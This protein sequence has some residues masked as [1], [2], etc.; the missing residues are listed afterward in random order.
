MLNTNSGIDPSSARAFGTTFPAG[1]N[2][3][4]ANAFGLGGGIPGLQNYNMQSG[5]QNRGGFGLPSSAAQQQA[6]QQNRFAGS[7]M[8]VNLQPRGPMGQ[9]LMGGLN[10]VGQRGIPGNAGLGQAALQR[11]AGNGVNMG[12]LGGASGMQRGMQGGMNLPGLAN[13]RGALGNIGMSALGGGLG[14]GLGNAL[15][16]QNSPGRNSGL[17]I[18]PG[19]GLSSAAYPPSGDLIAMMNKASVTTN[20]SQLLNATQSAFNNTVGQQQQQQQQQ[21]QSQQQRQQQ[22]QQQQQGQQSGQG[23]ATS[24][25]HDHDQPVFDQSEFP[26]LGGGAGGQR[27]Q[28]QGLANGDTTGFNGLGHGAN[29]YNNVALQGKAAG[30]FGADF[31]IQNESEFPALGSVGSRGGDDQSQDNQGQPGQKGGQQALQSGR[32]TMPMP[33]SGDSSQGNWHGL[34]PAVMEQIRSTPK[35][36]RHEAMDAL[37]QSMPGYNSYRGGPP[38]TPTQQQQMSQQQQHSGAGGKNPS[39]QAA[40][41]RFGLL[42]LLSVIRMTDPDLTTLALGTDLTTLGLHLN[43]PENVYKTFQSPW[44]DNPLRPE[45]DFKVPACYLHNPPRLQPGYFSKFQQ[46]TL[47]FIFYSMPSDEAQLFAADELASRGWWFH[48]EGK[49]W[50]T[51][52][53]NTEPLLKTDRYERGSYYVFDTN[54][55]ECVRKDSFHLQYDQLERP[56]NLPRSAPQPGGNPGISIP[57]AK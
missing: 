27:Q 24:M 28:T 50:L 55:W 4:G 40:P 39:Q 46:D 8:G 26:A 51:R 54:M 35:G 45:P 31:S 32:S 10:N 34:P 15:G 48:R 49:V 22:Q 17:S 23:Q 3:G 7:N 16:L 14:A 5:L 56:P 36:Q 43:S 53:P 29:M 12:A 11:Q 18:H 37:M 6:A 38:G 44:V 52:I 57:S 13:Q 21:Q 1:Q 47:F 41:D 33:G 42:G 20:N 25:G 2:Q 19:V 30:H 9:T